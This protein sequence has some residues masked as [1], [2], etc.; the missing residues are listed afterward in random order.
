MT[1]STDPQPLSAAVDP[2]IFHTTEGIDANNPDAGTVDP[3][4][5]I[6]VPVESRAPQ[7]TGLDEPRPPDPEGP[8]PPGQ[9]PRP[10]D[11]NQAPRR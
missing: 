11:P 5:Q 2:P 8:T 7:N 4:K 9:A 3:Q 10:V 1:G 6:Y